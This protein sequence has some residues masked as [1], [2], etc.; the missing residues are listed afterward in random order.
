MHMSAGRGAVEY[1]TCPPDLA[2]HQSVSKYKPCTDPTDFSVPRPEREEK[3][4]DTPSDLSD[5][6]RAASCLR[7]FTP[8][9]QTGSHTHKYTHTNTLL[10]KPVENKL[11]PM[12]KALGRELISVNISWLSVI[13]VSMKIPGQPKVN[14][15]SCEWPLTQK[16]H[17]KYFCWRNTELVISLNGLPSSPLGIGFVK[18]GFKGWS[19]F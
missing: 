15:I 5:C 18:S 19:H 12:H 2:C 4:D 3:R 9:G 6:F 16:A 11:T 10:H 14:V 1:E 7:Q 8:V 17:M 13:T